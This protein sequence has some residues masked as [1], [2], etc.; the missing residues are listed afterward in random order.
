MATGLSLSST[1]GLT[2]MSKT[3]IAEAIA[4]VE[5]SAPMMD[6]VSR[7]DIPSGSKQVT[8]PIWGRQSAVA[9][10]EGV[11]IAVPQQ[12]SSTIVSLTASEHG[13]LSFITDRLKHENNEDVLSAVGTMHGRA[14]GRLLDGD[15][16][17]LLDSFSKSV[18]GSG[19]A[20]TL[21][22]IAGAVAYLRTDN[23]SGSYG[24]APSKPNAV[25]NPEQIRRLT[26]DMAGITGGGTSMP[27]GAIPDGPSADILRTYW[28]GNDPVFGVPIYEDGNIATATN[29]KGG[30][31]A[32]EAMALAMEIEIHAEEER[33]ASLRGTEIVTVGIWGESQVVDEWGVEIHSLASASTT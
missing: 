28:R 22:T 33:D 26:Q 23:S 17:T 27:A 25:L 7:Y 32:K 8:I 2:S 15:L 16:L 10:T 20:A 19:S 29:V 21:Q 1:T 12:M 18:P 11:D 14:V 31:F 30:V 24:P 6:L 4:N 5:Q 9:L 13:I 3:L